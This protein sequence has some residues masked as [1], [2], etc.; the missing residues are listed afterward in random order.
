MCDNV[1]LCGFGVEKVTEFQLEVEIFDRQRQPSA[2]GGD[3]LEH[4]GPSCL[5]LEH[6]SPILT[7][8][9]VVGWF[10]D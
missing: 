2:G 5:L 10:T 6:N 9:V 3:K 7:K 1:N 4:F 8:S